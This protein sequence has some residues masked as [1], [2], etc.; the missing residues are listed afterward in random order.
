[1]WACSCAMAFAQSCASERQSNEYAVGDGASGTP[2]L[3]HSSMQLLGATPAALAG[4]PGHQVE[5]VVA[6][7]V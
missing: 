1:M 3:L 2:G 4:I 5:S 6:T 7:T